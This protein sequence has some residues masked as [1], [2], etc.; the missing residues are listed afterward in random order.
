ML[1]SRGSSDRELQAQRRR[2]LEIKQAA[3][4]SVLDG[5][6]STGRGYVEHAEYG[7]RGNQMTGESESKGEIKD[8]YT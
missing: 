7:D 4:A 3:A 8:D 6:F 5:A 1:E 2:A